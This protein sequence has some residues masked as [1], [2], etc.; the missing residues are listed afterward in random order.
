MNITDTPTDITTVLTFWFKELQP[1]DWWRNTELDQIIHTRFLPLFEKIENDIP[2]NWLQTPQ[3]CLAA[4]IILDQFPRNLFR[5]NARAFATDAKA[6]KITMHALENSFEKNLNS[7]EKTFLYIPL[8][9]SENKEDQNLSVKLYSELTDGNS[10]E[11]AKEH[12]KVIDQFGR[13]PHRNEILNRKSTNAELEYLAQHT[14]N[15]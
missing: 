9:H 11:F 6:R 3:G 13:F 8:Q 12:K 7:P 14:N 10:F 2:D 5:G 1:S 15:W 4:I